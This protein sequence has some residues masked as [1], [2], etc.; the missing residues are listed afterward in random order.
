MNVLELKS[1]SVS[2]RSYIKKNG[3]NTMDKTLNIYYTGDNEPIAIAEVKASLEKIKG[4]NIMS[5]EVIDTKRSCRNAY[6]QELSEDKFEAIDSDDEIWFDDYDFTI[7]AEVSTKM[8]TELL[9]KH[10]EDNSLSLQIL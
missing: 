10:C 3:G 4:I 1:I 9:L 8:P 7:K 5:L 2:L 6:G